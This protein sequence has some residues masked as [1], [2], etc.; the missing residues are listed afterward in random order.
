MKHIKGLRTISGCKKYF[1]NNFC[2][3]YIVSAHSPTRQTKQ[4][5]KTQKS[6]NKRP[7][8]FRV[9]K[10]FT[11]KKFYALWLYVRPV[12]RQYNS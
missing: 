6:L 10:C 4:E 9:Y 11:V 1:Y 12:L 7:W 5:D 8:I 3:L 2:E